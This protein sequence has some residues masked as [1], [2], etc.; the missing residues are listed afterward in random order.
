MCQ[1]IIV[2]VRRALQTAVPKNGLL[3]VNIMLLRL[4]GSHPKTNT[5]LNYLVLFH[6]G[7]LVVFHMLSLPALGPLGTAPNGAVHSKH[8]RLVAHTWPRL[9]QSGHPTPPQKAMLS[10]ICI[11]QP[12]TIGHC[13]HLCGYAPEKPKIL[14]LKVAHGYALLQSQL[15]TLPCHRC[16]VAFQRHGAPTCCATCESSCR[17]S[18][19]RSVRVTA[20]S[21]RQE[22][23][24]R[25]AGTKKGESKNG[26]AT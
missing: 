16:D 2:G 24:R 12:W 15:Q 9:R 23:L 13:G 5:F 6:P 25:R 21:P 7:I 22:V 10:I 18:R 8:P 26:L 17:S 3:Q 14:P 4:T 11:S 1:C 19:S 20:A